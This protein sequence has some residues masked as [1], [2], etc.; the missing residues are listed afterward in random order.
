M[1]AAPEVDPVTADELV[2][3]G[4][5]LLDVREDDEFVA[6]HA[7]AAVHVALG[8]LE[9]RFGELPDD[10]VVVCVCRSGARSGAAAAALRAAGLDARNLAGG[11]QAWARE[12]LPV[13]RDGGLGTVL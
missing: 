9:A 2:A 3:G 10:C 12:G 13:V 11:M 4:A 8:T 1:D 7:P 5:M 6:G